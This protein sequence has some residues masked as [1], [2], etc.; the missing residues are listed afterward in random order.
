MESLETTADYEFA[1][2]K[3]GVRVINFAESTEKKQG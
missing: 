3:E 1:L 2:D